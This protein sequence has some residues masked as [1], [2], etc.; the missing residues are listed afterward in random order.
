MTQDTFAG[1]LV[2]LTNISIGMDH[3][4]TIAPLHYHQKPKEQ[5]PQESFVGILV[6]L[7]SIFIGM[8][9]VWVVAL[10]HWQQTSKK[11]G[12]SV[13]IHVKQIN[14]YLGMALAFPNV[15]FR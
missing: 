4:Q 14:I 11:P 8:G 2:N 5:I 12:T 9:P 15:R 7:M 3:V 1:T 13:G 6:N 10:H